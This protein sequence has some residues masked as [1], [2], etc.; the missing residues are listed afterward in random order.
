MLCIFWEKGFMVQSQYCSE[1]SEIRN[2]TLVR[3]LCSKSIDDWR[4]NSSHQLGY[5]KGWRR[6]SFLFSKQFLSYHKEGVKCWP[7]WYFICLV[8]H[9]TTIL[10]VYHLSICD[11]GGATGGQGGDRPPLKVSKKEKKYG[12]FSCVKISISVI[13][14]KEIHALRGLLSR[15]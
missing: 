11:R 3:F 14:N 8:I 4:K 10:L 1:W 2:S 7:G 6:Y 9:L 13:F 15:F 5:T 12:V